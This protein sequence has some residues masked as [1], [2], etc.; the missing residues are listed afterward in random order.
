MLP[1]LLCVSSFAGEVWV[2]SPEEQGSNPW[3]HPK[4]RY[5]LWVRISGFHPVEQSSSLCSGTKLNLY[6]SM[7]EHRSYTSE[8]LA[9]FQVEVPDKIMEDTAG[10][11]GN[12]V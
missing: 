9:R 5:R 1:M 2:V 3:R 12:T 6:S 8:T 10:L 7:V 4:S 11:A